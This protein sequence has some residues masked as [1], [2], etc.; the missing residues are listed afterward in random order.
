M[1][2]VVNFKMRDIYVGIVCA[3]SWVYAGEW[4]EI[5]IEKVFISL[6]PFF[7]F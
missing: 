5:L 4:L 6:K 1:I 7:G 3:H 2:G